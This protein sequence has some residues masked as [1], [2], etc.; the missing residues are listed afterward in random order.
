MQNSDDNEETAKA[1][2]KEVVGSLLYL[3]TVTRPDIAFAVNA[4]SQYAESPKKIHWNAIK[5]I[6]KYVKGTIDYG[7]LF[8]GSVKNLRL[9]VLE[10]RTPR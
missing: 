2:Y 7:I 3:A 4:V 1:P 10:P 9:L 6:L 5:R 8:K